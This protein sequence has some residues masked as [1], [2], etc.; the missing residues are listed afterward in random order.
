MS[1][2]T[3]TKAQPP[4][5]G[6][7]RARPG[8]ELR[9]AENGGMPKLTGYM[10]R[11]NEPTV[12]NSVFE[13]RFIE[14]IAPGATKKTLSENRSMRIL[15]D[16][17]ADPSVG[18]KPLTEPRLV[19][20]T[21]GVRYDD[22]ELFDADYVRELLPALRARQLGSSFKFRSVQEEWT[23]D[24]GR[25]AENPEG[26]P[27]RRITEMKIYEGGPVVFPAYEGASAGVRS[28]TDRVFFDRLRQDPSRLPEVADLFASWIHSDPSRAEELVAQARSGET[29]GE[30]GE[31]SD[32]L[33]AVPWAILPDLMPMIAAAAL[34]GRSAARSDATAAL[35][36]LFGTQAG[37]GDETINGVAVI[38]LRGVITPRGS[39][40]GGGGLE[41]FREQL[42]DAVINDDVG[43][44]LL[45][46]DSPGGRSDLVAEAAADIRKARDEKQVV[47]VANARAASA[48]F[49]LASQASEVVVTPS[50][51]IGSVGVFL[52]HEDY[53]QMDAQM[54]I[55]TTLISAGKYK[56]EGNPY[57]PLSDEAKATF[58]AKVNEVHDAFLADLAKG[59][60][61]TV[62]D[63][64]ANFGEGRMVGPKD[65]V[66]AGMADRIESRDDA[67][68]RLSKSLQGRSDT[69]GPT[70]ESRAA[71]ADRSN[72]LP[73]GAEVAH[74]SR[75]REKERL[76]GADTAPSW[77]L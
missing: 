20:N 29:P 6:L 37:E 68:A 61:T 18:M 26:L 35:R 13:G 60:G 76:Y 55:K 31:P 16:H 47:A 15:F 69:G 39:L 10:L 9:A 5:D 41:S 21:Q 23:D 1:A 56:T 50:G 63:V 44:I 59:R 30:R 25:S 34:D 54:G 73:D 57:E 2:S 53:S 66:A 22:P 24:P 52:L 72:A 49:W 74:S 11:F 36:G 32:D 3:T 62:K 65:A 43:A 14:E 8:L 17:G 70:Q 19:E 7:V 42:H 45:D 40:F 71:D 12:I 38:P 27:V 46:I 28:M 58:Q 48:A 33:R 67:L 75:S 4:K 77:R 64:R 51:E